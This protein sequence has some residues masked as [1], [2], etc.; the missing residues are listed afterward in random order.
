MYKCTKIMKYFINLVIIILLFSCT[1]EITAPASVIEINITYFDYIPDSATLYLY[2]EIENT[3]DEILIDSVWVDVYRQEIG[4]IFSL[5]L[6]KKNIVNDESKNIHIYSYQDII[7]AFDS[8]NYRMKYYVREK[9]GSIISLTTNYKYLSAFSGD[10]V[11]EI[12]NWDIPSQI[13]INNT[14]W[15]EVPI[16]LTIFDLNG[17]EDIHSVKYQIKRSFNGCMKDCTIDIAIPPIDEVDC[18]TPIIDSNFQSDVTWTLDFLEFIEQGFK[19][20][21][22][23]LMRPLD[24]SGYAD[25]D[26]PFP[27]E[28]CGRTGNF[29]IRFIVSDSAGNDIIS[30]ATL[31]QVISE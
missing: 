4:E 7:P 8:D 19:Y 27:P 15:K 9:N 26:P 2:S 17:K 31:V 22:V 3:S 10:A 20:K 12:I 28:D 29:E 21:V 6:N 30:D 14:E 23:L 16:T 18:N 5:T 11:P 24:G 1:K 13:D 25:S